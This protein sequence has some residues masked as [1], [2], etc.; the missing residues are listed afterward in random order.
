MRRLNLTLEERKERVRAQTRAAARRHRIK[1]ASDGVRRKKRNAI[2]KRWRE[3]NKRK[4]IE[5]RQSNRE[6]SRVYVKKRRKVKPEEHRKAV[7]GWYWRNQDKVKAW[8]V[9][10]KALRNGVLKREGCDVCGAE[11]DGHHEDY[12]KPLEVIWLCR[13]HHKARHNALLEA[14]GI[15]ID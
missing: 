4:V 1:Y 3:K 6:L 8:R 12:E 14:K 10:K 7:M 15:K 9:Y 5:Y 11:A 2:C 13:L